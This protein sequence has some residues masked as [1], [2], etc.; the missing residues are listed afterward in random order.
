MSDLLSVPEDLTL[1]FSGNKKKRSISPNIQN[2]TQSKEIDALIQADQ[3]EI[4]IEIESLLRLV[5][6]EE[7]HNTNEMLYEFQGREDQ[8]LDSLRKMKDRQTE[9]SDSEKL[10]EIDITQQQQ[11]FNNNRSNPQAGISPAGGYSTNENVDGNQLKSPPELL[12][13]NNNIEEEEDRKLP[14]T[15]NNMKSY[16]SLQIDED[17][18]DLPQPRPIEDN[19][20]LNDIVDEE[21]PNSIQT[22]NDSTNFNDGMRKLKLSNLTTQSDETDD[23]SPKSEKS[24][25][26][27]SNELLLARSSSEEETIRITPTKKTTAIVKLRIWDPAKPHQRIKCVTATHILLPYDTNSSKTINNNGEVG[28]GNTKQQIKESRKAA[29][30]REEREESRN[31]MK[32]LSIVKEEPDKPIERGDSYFE[33]S[34]G[35]GELGKLCAA[36]AKEDEEGEDNEE[37]EED[38]EEDSID[39]R[40][41]GA[42]EDPLPLQEDGETTKQKLQVGTLVGIQ[43]KTSSSTSLPSRPTTTTNITSSGASATSTFSY[44][45]KQQLEWKVG[46]SINLHN[47]NFLPISNIPELHYQITNDY[48]C[49]KELVLDGLPYNSLQIEEAELLFD[50]LGNNTSIKRLSMRYSYVNDDLATLFALS[51]VTN[52]SLIQLVLEGNEMTTTSAKNFY[53][54][55]KKNN[56]T[57]RLLDVSSNPIDE[58]VLDAL[59]Q[60][61][62]QRA[63]KRTLTNKAEK[64]RRAARGLPPDNTLDNEDDETDGQVTVV[65]TQ[66][67]IDNVMEGGDK[68][69]EYLNELQSLENDNKPYPGED[70]RDYM[71]RMD[72]IQRSK[73]ESASYHKVLM[74]NSDRDLDAFQNFRAKALADSPEQQNGR[75]SPGNSMGSSITSRSTH[76]HRDGTD[77]DNGDVVTMNDDEEEGGRRTQLTSNRSNRNINSSSRNLK[78]SLGSE[79]FARGPPALRMS[80]ME[81]PSGQFGSGSPH[82]YHTLE[83][84]GSGSQRSG[85]LD[86]SQQ[87]Y[88]DPKAREREIR[89]RLARSGGAIGAYHMDEVAPQRQNR[90]GGARRGRM[91]RSASQRAARL[92]EIEGSGGGGGGGPTRASSRNLINGGMG[93][94]E[95]LNADIERADDYSAMEM[96]QMTLTNKIFNK[97]FAS[98]GLNDRDAGFDRKIC[99]FLVVLALALLV[100]VIVLATR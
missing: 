89:D 17:E 79:E 90:S 76:K 20:S 52:Q 71:Q 6:P 18:H 86:L 100:M 10:E 60:F 24:T 16:S 54:V 42:K 50:A 57:L 65:C 46:S 27:N 63:L 43:L 9:S 26:N 56:D 14:A 40:I 91:G 5:L 85:S 35:E 97:H 29:L 45:G 49:L 96:T 81:E 19:I 23:D 34:D 13:N 44:S 62:E 2:G 94:E 69:D 22:S 12:L 32:R 53:S 15:E 61:M 66:S 3:E 99:I 78:Q 70:F 88:M 30:I 28:K 83:S 77:Q 39:R 47:V 51:L 75:L 55:L 72:D 73:D 31:Q 59:D 21:I 8:L 82:P 92:A 41:N 74:D 98:F 48:R 7:V 1:S 84:G 4:R 95:V 58:D 67:M 25:D 11:P 68:D 64:A 36:V 38:E 33:S 80:G 93:D 87:D 37:N